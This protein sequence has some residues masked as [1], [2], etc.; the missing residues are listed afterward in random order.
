MTDAS[1][2]DE[3]GEEVV[4][5]ELEAHSNF[6]RGMLMIAR[7]SSSNSNEDEEEEDDDEDDAIT[8]TTITIHMTCVDVDDVFK[9]KS[10]SLSDTENR[11]ATE[12]CVYYLIMALGARG[13]VLK[14]TLVI[15]NDTD[16][17]DAI[18]D[19]F[20]SYR[21][22]PECLRLV[23]KTADVCEV[24]KYHKMRQ[25]FGLKRGYITALAMCPICQ[26][27]VYHTRLEC[28]HYIHHSCVIG[29]HARTP[30]D[31]KCPVCRQNISTS[32]KNRFFIM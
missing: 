9:V 21:P 2:S 8:S 24:C 25:Q 12:L 10:I 14:T 1:S 30:V 18:F 32:D 26:E 20:W 19:I 28:G 31:M 22:C 23:L 27:P 4:Y 17:V 7:P 11:H 5:P 13:N 6:L 15:P 29:L 16:V 3:H